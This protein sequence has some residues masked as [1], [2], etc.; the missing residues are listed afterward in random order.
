MSN[1]RK[2]WSQNSSALPEGKNILYISTNLAGVSR[3]FGQSCCRGERFLSSLIHYLLKA[4]THVFTLTLNPLYHSFIVL[5]SYRVCDFRKSI[6]SLD[7]RSLLPK[8]PILF[9]TGANTMRNVKKE[10]KKMLMKNRKIEKC[11]SLLLALC[12]AIDYYVPLVGM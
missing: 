7:N 8:H 3:P 5:S 11:F 2:T 10:R 12:N 4:F 1:V 6:S 9:Q